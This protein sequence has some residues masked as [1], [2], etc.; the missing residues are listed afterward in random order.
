MQL[1]RFDRWLRETFCYEI[2]IRTLR[3][4]ESVP[5]GVTE[6]PQPDD[7]TKRYKCL[8]VIRKSRIA[9]GFIEQ[10]K[11]AN[12]M[13]QTEIHERSGFFVRLVA[14]ADKSV[15]WWLITTTIITCSVIAVVLYVYVLFQNPELRQEF[16]EALK[17]FTT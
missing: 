11:E 15:T 12:Q 13:F 14:P 7:P 8:Y 2:H 10:L 16:F 6:V 4:A 3:P 5:K 17:L 1:T 9:D